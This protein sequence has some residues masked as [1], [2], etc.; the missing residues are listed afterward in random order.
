MLGIPRR[1][2]EQNE[3]DGLAGR[4]DRL[5]VGRVS[6]VKERAR[7]AADVL[8][9]GVQ[10]Q[11]HILAVAAERMPGNQGVECGLGNVAVQ[12]SV[13]RHIPTTD[14]GRGVCADRYAR[15]F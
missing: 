13:K 5:D 6:G 12:M 11:G 9:G 1:Q 7:D 3:S 10:R 15:S 14:P 8:S 2:P 4:I